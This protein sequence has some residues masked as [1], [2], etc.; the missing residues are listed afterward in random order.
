MEKVL[1]AYETALEVVRGMGFLEAMCYLKN[2]RL[3]YGICNYCSCNGIG[4]KEME[5]YIF[6][7]P[8]YCTTTAEIIETLEFRIKY[9]KEN[10][11]KTF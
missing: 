2:N 3:E 10:Y 11:E 6:K 4:F 9:L 1:E 8:Y 7:T 5:T